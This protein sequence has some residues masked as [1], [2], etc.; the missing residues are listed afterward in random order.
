MCREIP[1]LSRGQ[2]ESGRRTAGNLNW[3]SILNAAAKSGCEWYIV[4][5]DQN[6]IDNDP[7]ASIR[8]SFAFLSGHSLD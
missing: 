3:E 2:S 1:Y 7:F 8:M 6:W 5:Q 4:E